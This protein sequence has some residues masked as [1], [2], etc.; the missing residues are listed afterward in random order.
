MRSFTIISALLYLGSVSSVL[1]SPVQK[2]PLILPPS[3]A[4]HQQAV[5]NIFLESY[6]AYK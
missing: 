4:G 3:A 6:S 1:G 2:S 5:K